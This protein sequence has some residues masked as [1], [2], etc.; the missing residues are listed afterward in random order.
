MLPSLL[1]CSSILSIHPVGRKLSPDV[2]RRP[3][4]TRPRGSSAKDRFHLLHD[5]AATGG[6]ARQ[7]TAGAGHGGS[8][9]IGLLPPAARSPKWPKHGTS[10]AG[11]AAGSLL[12]L[13]RDSK[14]G[15]FARQGSRD[16][17]KLLRSHAH[18][19]LSQCHKQLILPV[20]MTCI[21]WTSQ[22]RTVCGT[23]RQPQHKL[24]PWPCI[25]GMP[26]NG[27]MFSGN[28]MKM[29]IELSPMLFR[30]QISKSI[31][32]GGNWQE[33][34]T[35]RI[36][37]KLT[38]KLVDGGLA[39]PNLTLKRG[40]IWHLLMNF[41]LPGMTNS[42]ALQFLLHNKQ[43]DDYNLLLQHTC[44]YRVPSRRPAYQPQC[45]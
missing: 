44:E 9:G 28:M 45:A 8:P 35:S 19:F 32:R 41:G 4:S 36:C 1:P 43:L 14:I 18:E 15:Y 16:L 37:M 31:A 38:G 21:S 7:S 42:A 11:P 12:N 6:K 39:S 34:T 26:Y 33:P 24:P 40:N 20:R 10:W 22:R 29:K 25:Y 27:N 2:A 30:L 13:R 23:R 5:L 3:P 17:F